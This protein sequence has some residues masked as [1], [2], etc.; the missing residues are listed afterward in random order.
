LGPPDRDWKLSPAVRLRDMLKDSR[1]AQVYL[2]LV[3]P[4]R[5]AF[6]K[7]RLYFRTDSHWSGEGCY[8]AYRLLC[9]RIGIGPD[10]DLLSRSYQSIDGV[11]DMGSKFDPPIYEPVK[12][13]DFRMKTRRVSSMRSRAISRRRNSSRKSTS[14]RMCVTSIPCLAPRRRRF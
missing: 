12:F 4:F 2:D 5:T 13:Y 6:D 9:E 11:L 3:E 8:F 7:D 1:C 10:P 14:A